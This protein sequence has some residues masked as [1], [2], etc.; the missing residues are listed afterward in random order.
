MPLPPQSLAAIQVAGASAFKAQTELGSAVKDYAAQVHSS[1]LQN[2][3]D[4]GNDALYEE[5]K[6]VARLA[7]AMGHIEAELRKIYAAAAGLSNGGTLTGGKSHTIATPIA[8]GTTF[9]EIAQEINA[10]DVTPKKPRKLAK[11]VSKQTKK[12]SALRGNTAKVL[13][14]LV[15]TLDPNTFSRINQSALAVAAG[16]PKGSIGAS[17]SKLVKEGYLSAGPQGGY[18]VNLTKA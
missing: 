16:L 7:Q 18:R 2:P 5:W 9:V 13:E 12:R 6:T 1:M 10:T 14:H 3:F 4:I 8:L 17:M 15:N 11:T